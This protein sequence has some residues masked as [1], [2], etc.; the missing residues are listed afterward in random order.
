MGH[1]SFHN[2]RDAHP[3]DRRDDDPEVIPFSALFFR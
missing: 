3:V 1:I 2:V